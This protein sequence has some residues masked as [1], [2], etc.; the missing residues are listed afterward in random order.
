MAYDVDTLHRVTDG[1]SPPTLRLFT[2]SRPTVSYGRLQRWATVA[3]LVPQN[4][5]AIQRPTGG[6]IVLHKDDLCLSLCWRRGQS[7][8][9]ERLADIYAWIHQTIRQ[10]LWPVTPL[11]MVTCRNDARRISSFHQ[12]QCFQEP[13]VFDLMEDDRKIVGG[14]LCRWHDT[15][16]YQGSIQGIPHR[17]TGMLLRNAFQQRLM[18]GFC[19][20]SSTSRNK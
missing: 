9:P 14:A 16:L 5:E 11:Q 3:P 20:V 12:R 6:G 18:S 4:W 13:A 10:A 2:W 17:A 19:A 1:S 15:V 7:P 8:L